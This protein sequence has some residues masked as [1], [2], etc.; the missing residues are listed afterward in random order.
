MTSA[1]R[2]TH[3]GHTILLALV[4]AVPMVILGGVAVAQ[5]HD[6]SVVVGVG[7]TFTLP[8]DATIHG[9]LV[10]T[11]GEAE[12][13][14]H[15]K[16]DVL[17]GEGKVSLRPSAVVDGSVLVV[18]GSLDRSANAAVAGDEKA[19]SPEQFAERTAESLTSER[20]ASEE[21]APDEDAAVAPVAAAEEPAEPKPPA[22]PRPPAPLS[23]K[24]ETRGDLVMLGS[25]ATV[26][27]DEVRRGDVVSFGGPVRIDGEV[28]GTVSSFGGPVTIRGKVTR[29]VVSFGGGVTLAEGS[30][31]QGDIASFGGPV[32]RATGARHD[33]SINSMGPGDFGFPGLSGLRRIPGLSVATMRAVSWLYQTIAALVIVFLVVM[34]FPTAT[35]VTAD[36]IFRNPGG[37]AAH[38]IITIL[39]FLP[40]CVLL[41][42][43]C[44]GIPVIPVL[45]LLL[46]LGGI[47]GIVAV[48]LIFG[49]QLTGATGWHVTS[50]LGLAIVGSLLL[51]AIGLLEFLPVIGIAAMLLAV[52]VAVLGLGGAVMTKFGVDPTG[53]FITDRVGRRNHAPVGAPEGM[54]DVADDLNTTDLEAPPPDPG[55]ASGEM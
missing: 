13:L 51:S 15:I 43:S 30:H 48:K 36:C 28:R 42:I 2:S 49:R 29:D 35:T 25:P 44:V 1:H 22:K 54:Q 33:G 11:G 47:L 24:P 26:P 12:V 53:R 14:G 20:A 17:L 45:F 18:K 4:V 10:V 41:A 16:G 39:L 8:P 37:A 52:C 31:L 55:D 50:T 5:D 3:T 7:Y 23:A 6:A 21:A 40:V 19:L 34:C 9:D 46:V 27:A 32:T 38:G